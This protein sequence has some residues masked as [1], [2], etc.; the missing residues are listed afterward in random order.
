LLSAFKNGDFEMAAAGDTQASGWQ[1]FNQRIRLG[2][3][4]NLA[5][6]PTPTDLQGAPQGAGE[7]A[8]VSGSESYSTQVVSSDQAA[9]GLA[10]KLASTNAT[11]DSF[12]VLHGPYVVSDS[13]V[14]L[15]AGDSVSF[16]WKAEGGSDDFDVYAYLLNEATGEKIELLNQTGSTTAWAKETHTVNTAGSYKFVFVSGTYDASGGTA[17]GAQLYID[18]VSVQS[19]VPSF[20]PTEA[21]LLAMQ[22]LVNYSNTGPINALKNSTNSLGLKQ[23]LYTGQ[24]RLERTD[25]KKE[26][27]GLSIDA[28]GSASD[29]QRLGFRAAAYIDGAA[30]DDLLVFVS[31]AGT[32]QVSA[33]YTLNP[34]DTKEQ[35]RN[36]PLTLKFISPTRF[37]LTDQKTGTLVAERNFDSSQ[38]GASISYQGLSLTFSNPPKTGDSFVLDG[39]RDGTGNNENM[40]ELVALESKAV[41]GNGKTLGS[42][43]I[44]QVNDMGNISRQASIVQSALTVVHDQAVASRDAVSGVSLDQEATELIRFQQAY[45]ASAKVMQVASQLFDSV[46]QIR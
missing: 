24:V 40:L 16:D 4:D 9:N 31:G 30:A 15:K 12:G 29:L 5:G 42:A 32:A 27:I 10:L 3:V 36:N 1:V 20:I 2:G 44:D 46:L 17:A 38:P 25:G 33:N 6:F 28:Q 41:M 37:T 22:S 18:N 23:G 13:P 39:N 43:Y 26:A 19:S 45:Q 7:T 34:V 35:L 11:I 8:A 14:Q 21:D